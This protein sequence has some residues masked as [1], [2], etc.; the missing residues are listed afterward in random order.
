[1]KVLCP[2]CR[3]ETEFA[4][5]NPYRPFCS[6]RCQLIDLGQWAEEK[7]AIPVKAASDAA[8]DDEEFD[9]DPNQESDP[10][11]EEPPQH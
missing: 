10:T 8:L 6:E 11:E 7:Y 4:K 1:M 5:E 2:R 9:Q 3:Q